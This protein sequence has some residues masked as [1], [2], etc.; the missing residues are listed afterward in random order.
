MDAIPAGSI[1]FMF[2]T[3]GLAMDSLPLIRKDTGY[4]VSISMSPSG[5]QMVEAGKLEVPFVFRKIL[6]FADCV[7]TW[8]AST[9]GVTYKYLFM[10]PSGKDLDQLREY[11]EN[12][13]L[14]PVVGNLV[15]YRDVDAVKEAC[16]VVFRSKGGIGKTVISFR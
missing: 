15:H 6:N 11:V 12:G 1:D 10:Q 9:W 16:D 3:L 4:V 5:D 8:R 2:D 7:R 14:R 13:Q